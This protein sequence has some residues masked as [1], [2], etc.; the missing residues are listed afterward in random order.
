MD[1]CFTQACRM[2]KSFCTS[3]LHLINRCAAQPEGKE[4]ITNPV[5]LGKELFSIWQNPHS[6]V[7][8]LS[9]FIS[10]INFEKLS[11]RSSVSEQAKLSPS[12]RFHTLCPWKTFHTL[13]VPVV[14]WSVYTQNSYAE[15]LT[16]GTSE[17]DLC[18]YKIKAD[19]IK[20]VHS[21]VGQVP[22]PIRLVS[23]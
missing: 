3:Y 17:C 13:T 10:P 16:S 8:V 15:V 1:L 23:F 14:D 11:I 7:L 9:L 4:G 21:S 12:V 5:K 6:K 22:H 20:W 18:G 19:V 2:G